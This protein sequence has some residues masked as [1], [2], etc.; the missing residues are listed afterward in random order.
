MKKIRIL[1]SEFLFPTVYGKWRAN[2][3]NYFLDNN[4]YECDFYVECFYE[5]FIISIGETV[6]EV[7]EKYYKI[8]RYLDNYNILI[9]NPKYNKLNKFNKN[10]DGK[11]Y[12]NLFRGD[13]MLTKSKYIPSMKE[14]DVFYGI[15]ITS[16]MNGLINRNNWINVC[17]IYPGGGYCNNPE[18]HKEIYSKLKA[19]NADVIVTQDFIFKD[20]IKY[21]NSDKVHKVYGVPVIGHKEKLN[22]K[23]SIIRKKEMHVCFSSMSYDNAKGFDNYLSVVEYFKKYTEMYNI[24]FHAIGIYQNI[25]SD[26]LGNIICHKVMSPDELTN[27]YQSEIDVIISPNKK[28]YEL[29]APDGFPLGSEAMICG[30]IPIIC[31]LYNCN[32]NYG[33]DNSNSFIMNTFDINYVTKSLITLYNDEELRLSMA[34]NIMKKSRELF[35]VENQLL[36]I[37]NVIKQRLAWKETCVLLSKIPTDTGGGCPV[38]KAQYLVNLIIKQNLTTCVEIGVYRGRSLIP[39]IVATSHI[40]GYVYGIDPYTNADMFEKELPIE[41]KDVVTEFIMTC[42]LESIYNNLSLLL[43]SSPFFNYRLL[44]LTSDRACPFLPSSINLLHIDG[45]HDTFFVNL[46]ITSHV[47]RVCSGGFIIMDDTNWQSVIASLPLLSKYAV[48]LEDFYS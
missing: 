8:F 7:F 41:I 47:P 9:F 37:S 39:M 10:I 42:D 18:T 24:V 20:A 29:D 32:V 43:S 33:L 4:E 46:D 45:N 36:P 17:K 26:L 6:E 27:F 15:F 22:D 38:D 14:Y 11:V 21:L 3:I 30:C 12:N 5:S 19:T 35:S 44:R 48:L 31:D 28:R 1:I 34:K 23:E 40:N 2:E 16:Y 13:F 25:P